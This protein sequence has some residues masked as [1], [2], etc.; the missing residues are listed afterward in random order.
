MF[1]DRLVADGKIEP[2]LTFEG[3]RHTAAKRRADLDVDPRLIARAL[4]HE[5]LAAAIQYPE[6]AKPKRCA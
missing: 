5:T 4:G 1:R 3:L 6:E 2:G